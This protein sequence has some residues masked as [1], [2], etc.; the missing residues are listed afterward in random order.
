MPYSTMVFYFPFFYCFLFFLLL[1]TL[2]SQFGSGNTVNAISK[3]LFS[4]FICYIL[5]NFTCL[6]SKCIYN[7]YILHL[8][9]YNLFSV[10]YLYSVLYIYNDIFCVM[11]CECVVHGLCL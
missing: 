9:N 8:L 6:N 2:F 1:V 4:Y 3:F 11:C 7:R 10:S 5:F